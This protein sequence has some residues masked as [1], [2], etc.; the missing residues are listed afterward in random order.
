MSNQ[1]S[2]GWVKGAAP[3]LWG[4]FFFGFK[5]GP[6]GALVAMFVTLIVLMGLFDALR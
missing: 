5:L 2:Y 1:N 6:W 3:I 4:V